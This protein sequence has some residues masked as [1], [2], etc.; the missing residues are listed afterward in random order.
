MKRIVQITM[1]F[2]LVFGAGSALAFHDGGVAYCAG[3]H[4]MHN[5]IDG[6][7]WSAYPGY[8]N[9]M[10]GN[11]KLLVQ[12]GATDT[13]LRCHASY[14]QMHDGSGY[15]A[16][17]DFYWVTKE[18]SWTPPWPGAQTTYSYADNHGHNVISPTYGIIADGTLTTAPGGTF[19]SDK[20]VCTSCHDPH[21]Q[22]TF[23]LLYSN[24]GLTDPLAPDGPIYVVPGQPGDTRFTFVEAAP[25][26]FGQGRK[27]T[28]DADPETD[29]L[30]TIYKSGMSDWCANCHTQI[31]SENTGNY[32][33]KTDEAM[34]GL[35][36]NYNSYVSSTN[37]DG[38][39]QA[40]AYNALVPFEDIDA[41]LSDPNDDLGAGA[42]H[43]YNAGPT[44]QDKVMCLTCHRAHATAFDDATRWDMHA[45]LLVDSHPK[46]GDTGATADDVLNS[47]YGR[48]WATIDINQ[49]SLC[50]KCHVKDWGD[51]APY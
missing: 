1:V 34:N 25:I 33:H 18:F 3:C 41:D 40:T 28:V 30:H 10:P 17:G 19:E 26:A 24:S 9:P 50:N 39:S 32:V 36:G 20:L 7:V 35:A 51:H 5:S 49:R 8:T 46:L 14:G 11:P 2:A 48:D 47:Y 22:D 29:D 21:G 13:C 6:D 43:D 42:T 27:T 15:G 4:T 38:G 31:H 44:G 12:P 16:G 23:R 45:D 37:L